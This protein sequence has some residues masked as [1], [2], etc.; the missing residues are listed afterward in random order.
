ML[1]V[2]LD[3]DRD[4]AAVGAALRDLGPERL[5]EAVRGEDERL[6]RDGG[7]LALVEASYSHV[8]AFAPQVLAALSFAASVTP[9]DVL[10]GVQLLQAMNAEGRRQVPDGAPTSFVPSRWRP[11][12]ERARAAGEE[13][14]HKHYWG[15]RHQPRGKQRLVF[16]AVDAERRRRDL[17]CCLDGGL[18]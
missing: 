9:S 10:D 2:V 14:L 1:D 11:Y 17:A 5:A 13:N 7:H 4:D 18:A 8:R 3:T 16:V 6:P 15:S 12:L